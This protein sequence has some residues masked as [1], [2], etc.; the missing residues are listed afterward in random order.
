[1]TTPLP[2]D[3]VLDRFIRAAPHIPSLGRIVQEHRIATAS[4]SRNLIGN[5][6]IDW[7]EQLVIEAGL[8]ITPAERLFEIVDLLNTGFRE[9]ETVWIGEHLVR[10]SQRHEWLVDMLIRGYGHTKQDDNLTGLIGRIESAVTSAMDHADNTHMKRLVEIVRSHGFPEFDAN[11]PGALTTPLSGSNGLSYMIV[12]LEHP[13][14]VSRVLG[15]V[16]A[17]EGH[18]YFG[19]VGVSGASLL[20]PQGAGVHV[21]SKNEFVVGVFA[22]ARADA[23]I[24]LDSMGSII[25]VHYQGRN[26]F[27]RSNPAAV[28]SVQLALHAKETAL[29]AWSV[30]ASLLSPH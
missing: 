26:V 21:R 14:R 10:F 8:G 7:A 17:P 22:G 29:A 12:R 11:C 1:M 27:D 2:H 15:L 16:V 4:R 25:E 19:E 28:P 13:D 18:W 20:K 5:L 3:W 6:Y 24:A 30:L 23:S 9:Q